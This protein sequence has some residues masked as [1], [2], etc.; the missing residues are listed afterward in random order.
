MAF[1]LVLG[2]AAP[3]RAAETSN[4]TDADG[5]AVAIPGS[6]T[7]QRAASPTLFDSVLR[8]PPFLSL[9]GVTS[10]LA[11]PAVQKSP[12]GVRTVCGSSCVEQHHGSL[13]RSRAMTGAVI[14]GV[15]AVGLGTALVLLL[16]QGSRSEMPSAIPDL[17]LKLS[18]QKGG[19]SV[20]WRF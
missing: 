11:K 18:G 2:F 8:L 1:V 7:A 17:Q 12:I 6:S 3:L 9:S 14:G 4:T 16:T 19:A 5:P 15:A 13:P 10:V 20:R